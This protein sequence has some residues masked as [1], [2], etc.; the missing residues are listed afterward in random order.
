MRTWAYVMNFFFIVQIENKKK[1]YEK[2][3]QKINRDIIHLYSINK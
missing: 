3:A 1:Y 2:H